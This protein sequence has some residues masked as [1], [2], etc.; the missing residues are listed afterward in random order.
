MAPWSVVSPWRPLARAQHS[1]QVRHSAPTAA[2]QWMS[3]GTGDEEREQGRMEDGSGGGGREGG[4][5]SPTSPS[6]ALPFP[7][8]APTPPPPPSAGH[9]PRGA[10]LRS[11]K[12]THMVMV[13]FSLAEPR[14]SA[15]LPTGSPVTTFYF[16]PLS[17]PPKGPS[18]TRH[19]LSRGPR[20]SSFRSFSGRPEEE[21]HSCFL[22]LAPNAHSIRGRSR[23]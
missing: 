13:T 8:H 1:W 4:E 19:T 16:S 14:P 20:C 21:M 10:A 5:S 6:L 11:C 2:G 22:V 9:S 15:A 23:F 17:T 3:E 18:R 7:G 12:P